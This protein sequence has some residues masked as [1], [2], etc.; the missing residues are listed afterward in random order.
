M[1]CGPQ[2]R[3]T[4]IVRKIKFQNL[5]KTQHKSTK[6]L[7]FLFINYKS[8]YLL[9]HIPKMARGLWHWFIKKTWCPCLCHVQKYFKIYRSGFFPVIADLTHK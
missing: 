8:W 1:W 3:Y 7:F 2:G 6:F 9:V 5:S 4:F